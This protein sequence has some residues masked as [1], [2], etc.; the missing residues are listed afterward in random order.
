MSDPKK[1][2]VGM[3]GGV[4]SSVAAL[5][6]KQQGYLV[7]GVMLKLWAEEGFSRENQCCSLES[8][9]QA[10]RIASLIGI[11]FYLLDAVDPFYNIVVNSF[12]ES[13]FNGET[14]NPCALCNPLIRWHYLTNYADA[15]GAQYI[16]TGHYARTEISTNGDA[17]LFRGYD[18]HKDQSYIISRLPQHFLRRSVFP[19]AEMLKTDVREI[20][21]SHHLPVTEKPDS[22]DICFIGDGDYRA[23]LKRVRPDAIQPGI[24]HDLT[25]KV[26]GTHQG[27]PYYTVG[28]RK[29]IMIAAENPLYVVKKDLEANEIIVGSKADF[30]VNEVIAS[31]VNWIRP[32][33]E[34]QEIQLLAQFRYKSKPAAVQIEQIADDQIRIRLT[35]DHDS[36]AIGQIAVIYSP[37]DEVIASGKIVKTDR[38]T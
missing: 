18:P 8:V 38:Y 31:D 23:F 16:A 14:P 26:R 36:I 2:V 27:L 37:D 6:L 12:I 32:I 17:R 35:A 25:G 1:V 4:D 7:V 30:L 13:Y 19:L 28:Q 11:P 33:K 24:I 34:V 9:E 22:Q 10:R 3:S 29:G 5:L 15:I 20:S 21:R